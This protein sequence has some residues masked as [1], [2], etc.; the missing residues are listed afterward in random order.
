[1]L[2]EVWREWCCVEFIRKRGRRLL[3]VA[4]QHL[5]T[6]L[7]STL[8][9]PYQAPAPSH[10]SETGTDWCCG[11]LIN[12]S[13]SQSFNT[14]SLQTCMRCD[15]ISVSAVFFINWKNGALLI[16]EHYSWS[17]DKYNNMSLLYVK[18][19]V[20]IENFKWTTILERHVVTSRIKFWLVRTS[21]KGTIIYKRVIK[22]RIHS[23]VEKCIIGTRKIL[24]LMHILPHN[25]LKLGKQIANKGLYKMEII[26][27]I[28]K[29]PL[30]VHLFPL[31]IQIFG[32]FNNIDPV[33]FSTS[34]ASIQERRHTY[35]W[36]FFLNKL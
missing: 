19:K 16:M 24:F 11:L 12:L 2:L 27:K 23:L 18:S 10:V 14:S 17:N 3:I 7:P 35:K 26:Y 21:R 36:K 6:H 1:M 29:E 20:A 28:L 30:L 22:T 25:R 34:W 5:S 4:S 15:A 32:S 8:P 9:H 33:V 31:K 13:A